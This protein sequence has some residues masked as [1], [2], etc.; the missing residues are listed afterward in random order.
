MG[1]TTEWDLEALK[2]SKDKFE[3]LITNLEIKSS[4]VDEIWKI[5]TE[6][7]DQR[8]HYIGFEDVDSFLICGDY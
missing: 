5:Q 1:L 7:S 4:E 6:V 8:C 2:G 3:K